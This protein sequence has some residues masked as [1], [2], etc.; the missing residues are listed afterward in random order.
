MD[1]TKRTEPPEP[2]AAAPQKTP[3]AGQ[4]A[5]SRAV[6]AVGIVICVA[7]IV[8]FIQ[9]LK[10]SQEFLPAADEAGE[11]VVTIPEG[12]ATA[13]IGQLL[14]AGGAIRSARAF[15]WAI[16]LQSRLKGRPV[17]LKAG[18]MA[19]DPSLPVWGVID[20]LARGTYKLHPFTVPEGRNMFEIAQMVEA[21]GLGDREEFLALCRDRAFIGSLGLQ[22]DSLEGYLFPETYNFPKGTPLKAVIKTMVDSFFT[23]WGKY[24]GQAGASNL[25]RHELV[26]LASL[27]EKET[28]APQERPIIAGVFRNRLQKGMKLQTDPSVVYGLPAFSGP[29]TKKELAANHPYNTYVIDGLPPGPIANPGEA[30]LAAAVNPAQVGYLYFVSKN[31][32][33]H[34]FSN[35]L[36]E[37]NR[38][39]RQYQR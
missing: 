33:T 3:R 9:G 15:G 25:S 1:T 36:A 18:E 28:A 14:Q 16:R 38:A 19:L 29:I 21:A 7:L 35:T 24:D 11:V 10:F 17:V 39:V 2:G 32:G 6:G 12:A 31:D 20:Q 34:Q 30:S 4:S 27:V 22:E 8:A 26:T 13:R 23:V 5:F 37:H